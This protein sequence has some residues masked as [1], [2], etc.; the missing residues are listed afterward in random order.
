MCYESAL[1][2]EEHW[3][4]Q[5]Q[6][7][8]DNTFWSDWNDMYLAFGVSMSC[9][10][11][12]AHAAGG[13]SQT[14]PIRTNGMIA[15]A[16]DLSV[17]SVRVALSDSE[18]YSQLFFA[19]RLYH[20]FERYITRKSCA[21]EGTQPLEDCLG[22]MVRSWETTHDPN[23][24]LE[25]AKSIGEID[26]LTKSLMNAL[27]ASATSNES[28][29]NTGGGTI[30]SDTADNNTTSTT[31]DARKASVMDEKSPTTKIIKDV[32]SMRRAML[33]AKCNP[34]KW[35]ISEDLLPDALP[36]HLAALPRIK[37]Q[38]N[39]FL[40]P[41]R[42]LGVDFAFPDFNRMNPGEEDGYMILVEQIV[43]M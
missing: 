11:A 30:A 28:P 6:R 19:A 37:V 23:N 40:I 16:F 21:Q 13:I 29:A 42:F 20:V 5:D 7:L 36:N 24:P 8:A 1:T 43:G 32:A 33:G 14:R 10:L 39:N 3:T 34:L 35:A 9:N 12:L 2:F 27:I 26:Q 22:I 25:M 4:A 31:V 38:S 18:Q 41:T 17:I 15:Q